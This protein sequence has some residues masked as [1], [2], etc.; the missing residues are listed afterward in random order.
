MVEN[1]QLRFLLLF[2][3]EKTNT[4]LMY[5]LPN[6]CMDLT[7]ENCIALHITAVDCTT[8]QLLLLLLLL[9]L[10]LLLLLLYKIALHY[11]VW[12]QMNILGAWIKRI[13]D[14]HWTRKC[15]SKGGHQKNAA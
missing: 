11:T 15:L 10:Q 5:V 6:K 9:L 1:V 7:V 8:L 2:C 14:I 13:S 4:S 3:L 12:Y